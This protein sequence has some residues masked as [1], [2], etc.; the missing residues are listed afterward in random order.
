M[1]RPATPNDLSAIKN[2]TE[3][4]AAALQKKKIF[5]WNENYPSMEK[6]SSDIK[7]GEL[8]VLLQ[9]KKITGIVALSTCMDD[10]YKPVKW[11]TNTSKN[12]YAHRLAVLPE[13]WGKG[14]AQILMDFAEDFA[15]SQNCVSVR[16]DTFSQNKR[17]HKFYEKRGYQKL[18]DIHFPFKSKHPFH[19]YELVL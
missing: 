7:N 10:V 15:R 2:L 3:A 11:L 1:I 4:C 14:F 17:N 19:C 13:N 18:E 16:L 12:L 9:D 6:L 8:Y 5:Q